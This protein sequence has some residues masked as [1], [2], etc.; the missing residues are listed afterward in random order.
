[1]PKNLCPVF[2]VNFIASE[3]GN[4]KQYFKKMKLIGN[5]RNQFQM[6]CIESLVS[7]ESRARAVAAF[8]DFLD[9]KKLG[10]KIKG[11]TKNG[12]PAYTAEDLLK[13]YFYEYMNRV[14][15]SRRLEREAETNIEAMWLLK[16]LRPCYK[17]IADFRKDNPAAFKSFNIFLRDEGLFRMIPLPRTARNSVHRTAKRTIT[18]K[19]K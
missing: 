2:L 10:Y 14:R 1:M 13:L 4:K 18:T 12:R 6:I 17:T 7:P 19:R 16:G 8:V 11:E 5:D 9:V 3:K 15:S